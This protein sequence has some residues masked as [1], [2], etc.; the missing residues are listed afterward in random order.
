MQHTR[1]NW[2]HQHWYGQMMWTSDYLKPHQTCRGPHH[3]EQKN[4]FIQNVNMH[5]CDLEKLSSAIKI[6]DDKKDDDKK[7]KK[8]KKKLKMIL[9]SQ[10]LLVNPDWKY[11]QNIIWKMCTVL[12]FKFSFLF[13]LKNHHWKDVNLKFQLKRSS[14]LD[15]Q[16]N[17]AHCSCLYLTV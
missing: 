6:V 9:F 1:Y 14:Q 17:S 4:P 12:F 5:M 7:K 16:S 2:S 10:K 15:V 13:Q 3:I 11:Y 8:K